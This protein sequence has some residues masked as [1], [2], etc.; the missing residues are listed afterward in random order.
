MR[1]R[2]L[3]VLILGIALAGLYSPPLAIAGPWRGAPDA[4]AAS[5][6]ARVGDTGF[7]QLRA[8]SLKDISPTRRM[9]AYWLARAAIAVNPIAYDQNSIYGLREKLLLVN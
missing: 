5:L 7:I 9:D 1:T 3:P 6:V 8:D 4:A 2:I